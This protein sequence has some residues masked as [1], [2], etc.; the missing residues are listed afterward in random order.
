[1]ERRDIAQ[2]AICEIKDEA[3]TISCD[4]L[5]QLYLEK[6]SEIIYIIKNKQLYGII[7]L[8]EVLH[9]IEYS[10]QIKINKSFTVLVG[11]NIVKAYRIFAA[12]GIKK[13]PVVNKMGELIGEYSKWDDLLFI[14]RNQRM[15]M[16]GEGSKKILELYDT[17][18]VVKPIENKQ[19]FFGLLIKCLI[20]S[21]IKY[22]ILHKEQIVNKILENACFIFVDEDEKIGTECLIEINLSLY[23]KQKH[24]LDNKNKLVNMKYHS[25]LTTY[26]SLLIKIMQENELYNMKIIKPEFIYGNQVDDL[27]SIFFSELVKKGVK[28]FCLIS[29][30]LEG[31]DKLSEYTEKFNEEIKERL[32]KYPLSIKEPWPKKNQNPD[33]YDDLYQNEDYITEKAQKEIFG[34][35]AVYDKSSVYGKYFN[36]RNGRRITCFQPEEN[37]GTIYLFGKCMILGTLVEDQYTIASILQK[38][39]IEKEY[40]YRVENYG[41]LASPYKLDE[42]LEEIGQ[43]CKNDIVIY[44]PTDLSR[45]FVNI[46]QISWNQIFE[47]HRIPSTWVTDSFIHENHK[48]NQ[49][50]AGD[51]LEI[52]EPYLSK[53]TISNHQ[54]VQFN[55]YDIMKKYIEYKYWNKYFADCN[56][57][58]IGQSRGALT[59]DCDPFDKRHRYLIEQAGQQ[60]DF[61]ILFITENDGYRS[62]LFPF[63]QR[64]KMVVEGTMD[65]KNIMI[66]PSGL[67]DLL[68]TNFP[69]NL[70]KTE[71]RVYDYSRYYI[72]RFVDYI[73]RP[74][75]ITRCFVEKEPEQEIVKMFNEVM[76]EILPQKEISCI[77]IPLI[78][79]NND[80][81]TSQIQKNLRKEEYE[82]AFKM[83]V[84]TTKQSCME[85]AGLV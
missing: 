68:G 43:F 42:K 74:L 64:F 83:M 11:H 9:K 6:T 63:E 45:Q 54:K 17:I 65:L 78:P 53:G 82:N 4:E 34:E 81:N 47:R 3:E 37:V 31:T 29:E 55:V 21:G 1:M 79:D 84:E 60:V 27:A 36:A 51:I 61:L 71:Q 16:N 59:M 23:D 46:P 13:L 80:S 66:V 48:A 20:D 70:I 2:L 26:K 8:K 69:R 41:D 38:N 67:F 22:E 35:S 50:V 62:C 73:A 25:K 77:E 12:K 40:L 85:L 30:N 24:Y 18:Y 32:K 75:H 49:V 76:K 58:F 44:F 57:K 14:K 10:R 39:L 52:V 15:L 72:N 33:F 19:S 56:K 28:C 5:R 7:C